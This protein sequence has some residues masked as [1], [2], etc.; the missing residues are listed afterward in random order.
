LNSLDKVIQIKEKIKPFSKSLNILIVETDDFVLAILIKFLSPLFSNVFSSKN[1]TEAIDIFE[2]ESIDL[3][4][5][6]N[7]LPLR[8]GI[9][10][11]RDI[12]AL[13]DNVPIILLTAKISD[14]DLILALNQRVTQFVLKPFD[15]LL[16]INAIDI[17]INKV[18]VKEIRAKSK[19]AE[20]KVL[21]KQEAKSKV[22]HS[23]AFKKEL[24]L[25][26]NDLYYKYLDMPDSSLDRS[27]L[28]NIHYKPLDVLS[29]DSYSLRSIDKNRVLFF[30]FDAMGKGVSASISTVLSTSLINHL[31]D[32]EK[33]QEKFNF[34]CLIDSYIEFIK[35]NILDDEIVSVTF[36]LL[37]IELETME[38]SMFGMPPLLLKD[39]NSKITK[40]KSN[41][42]PICKYIDSNRIDNYCIKNFDKILF[43]SDGLIDSKIKGGLYSEC[44]K[45]DFKKSI[46]K[47][48]FLDRIDAKIKHQQDDLTLIYFN[49]LKTEPIAQKHIEI[50]AM[51]SELDIA[52]EEIESFLDKN[53]SNENFKLEFMASFFEFLFN[54][55]EHGSFGINY[56]K[57][58]N[59]ME[60][61]L[62]YD[63]LLE[64]EKKYGL[65]R[66]IYINI[67]FFKKTKKHIICEIED[68]GSGFDTSILR[69]KLINEDE[70]HGRGVVLAQKTVDEIYY[71]YRANKVILI[72][73][74]KDK[75]G[76]ED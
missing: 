17:C 44:I 20:I 41:N 30:L 26:E 27:W 52:T 72:K 68:E 10:M 8:S 2:K 65:E 16:I 28:V 56:E 14:L 76:Y 4:I 69:N 50:N 7:A 32:L 21:K 13:D 5:T 59:L 64:L 15:F 29:G 62:Y 60:S 35:K 25:I 73:V 71:N 12:R 6:D 11:I 66:K 19:D 22:E 48:E 39:K 23:L 55:Y 40:I 9:D 45:K 46:Y 37:N 31:I 49:R 38:L 53:I 58:Q 61:N 1:A 43:Y 36:V 3:I 42:L 67:R 75:N 33:E 54:A 74:L 57:K 70:F 63:T 18:I 24:N 34:Q 47:S 51:E